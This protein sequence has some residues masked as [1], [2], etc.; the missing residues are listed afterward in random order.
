MLLYLQPHTCP[1]FK[2]PIL[3]KWGN[4]TS[5]LPSSEDSHPI[6]YSVYPT[7]PITK[8]SKQTTVHH[9]KHAYLPRCFFFFSLTVISVV[10]QS[11]N[12]LF[13]V[14]IWFSKDWKKSTILQTSKS[15]HESFT[16]WKPSLTLWQDKTEVRTYY[17]DFILITIM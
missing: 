10:V 15:A 14:L 8:E 7:C 17:W 2:N 1:H 9:F 13:T 6:A 4:A 12:C 5:I 11:L 16:V 3:P